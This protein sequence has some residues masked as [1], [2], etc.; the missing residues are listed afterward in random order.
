MAQT[1]DQDQSQSNLVSELGTLLIDTCQA[2]DV[3]TLET[4]RQIV[5]DPNECKEFI[6]QLGQRV[7]VKVKILSYLN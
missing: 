5:E 1:M 6:P 4:L 2:N 7:K 3:D